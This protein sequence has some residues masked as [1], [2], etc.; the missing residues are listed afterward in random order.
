VY[1]FHYHPGGVSTEL[2]RNLPS[3]F[4]EM[5]NDTPELAGDAMV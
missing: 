3:P 4:V 1:S 2:G 5:L